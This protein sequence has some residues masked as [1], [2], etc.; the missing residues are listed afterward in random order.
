MDYSCRMQLVQRKQ[1]RPDTIKKIFWFHPAM[2][3]HN[4]SQ[5]DA[6]DIFHYDISGIIVFE[7]IEDRNQTGF[8][9]K[10]PD[11]TCF[12]EESFLFCLAAV[13][14]VLICQHCSA[15][16]IR[17][18]AHIVTVEELLNGNAF[19]RVDIGSFIGYSETALTKRAFYSKAHVDYGS[20]FKLMCLL[21]FHV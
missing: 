2:F 10:V 9:R 13:L 12:T 11:N 8:I 20:R 6:I 7:I 19:S 21:Y 18:P 5:C 16:S 4:L 14:R 17:C 3:I 1:Q 15:G